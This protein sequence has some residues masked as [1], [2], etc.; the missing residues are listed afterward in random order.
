VSF[1]FSASPLFSGSGMFASPACCNIDTNRTFL[2]VFTYAYL[3]WTSGLSVLGDCSWS[4]RPI[5]WATLSTLARCWVLECRVL[6]VGPCKGARSWDQGQG[7]E[8]VLSRFRGLRA[9]LRGCLYT[10]SPL[11]GMPLQQGFRFPCFFQD[12]S[13]RPSLSFSLVFV[14]LQR[15][16]HHLTGYLFKYVVFP[17]MVR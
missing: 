9:F 8:P 15:M 7:K 1:L 16:H 6:S 5:L 4:P 2:P 14:S 10:S 11:S 3:P 12:L 13:A 17:P